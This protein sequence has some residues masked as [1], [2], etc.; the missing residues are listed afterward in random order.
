MSFIDKNTKDV[1]LGWFRI[2]KELRLID[3]SYTQI[4]IQKDAGNE[5]DG[6]SIV[7]VAANN[8]YGVGNIPQRSF[9][10]S[11]FDEQRVK[12]NDVVS[13]QYEK[14]L[15]GKSTVKKSLGLLGEFMEGKIK[16]K[17]T[18]LKTPPNSPLT[19]KLKKSSNPLIDTG[20]MR[21]SIRHVEVIEEK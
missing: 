15:D 8:E 19:I 20:T 5:E 18:D 13:K 3:K 10:R 16:R 11:T 7:E 17:I 2:K 4:G 21:A 12:I 1:D 14:I 9:M 6:K